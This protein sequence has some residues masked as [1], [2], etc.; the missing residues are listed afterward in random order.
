MSAR[1][2]PLHEIVAA[3]IGARPQRCQEAAACNGLAE[4]LVAAQVSNLGPA[5]AQN[6]WS[7]ADERA[8]DVANATDNAI[9]A[10]GEFVTV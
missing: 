6:P 7:N 2:G 3:L 9:G 10:E 5:G 4:P 1:T 8:K